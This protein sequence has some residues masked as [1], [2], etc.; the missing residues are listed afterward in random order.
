MKENLL[1]SIGGDSLNLKLARIINEERERFTIQLG[2]EEVKAVLSGKLRHQIHFRSQMPAVGD[3]VDV[4]FNPLEGIARIISIRPRRSQLTRKLSGE[5]AGEQILA[6][7]I[8]TALVLNSLNRDL[9]LRRIE[10]YLVMI[11]DG[12]IRP[13]LVLT[14]SDLV[15]QEEAQRLKQMVEKVAGDDLVICSSILEPASLR[16][17]L[18]FFHIDQTVALIGSSGVGKSTL[19]NYLLNQQVQL[20]QEIGAYADRG[21]HTTTSRRLFKTE[22]GAYLMDTPGIREIQLWSGEDGFEHSF[23]DVLEL[24]GQCRF[25]N[26][27]HKDDLGCAIQA[28]I[29]SGELEEARLKSFLKIQREQAYMEAKEKARTSNHLQHIWK[30]RGKA[31]RRGKKR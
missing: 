13:V 29:E 7:N 25:S 16:P 6:A 4:T 10:R 27:A 24:M 3:Y 19:T 2:D 15:D 30:V 14:K 26:C 20:V 8:D 22:S 17:L 21:R 18:Q 23:P 9:N 11:R 5:H 12:G 31:Y 1:K 28:A